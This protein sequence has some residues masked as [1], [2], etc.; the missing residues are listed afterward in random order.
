MLPFEF[1]LFQFTVRCRE[2]KRAQFYTV[3]PGKSAPFWPQQTG[4]RKLMVASIADSF[5]ETQ[6]FE[7]TIPN[8]T[9]LRLDHEVKGTSSSKQICFF[10][11]F[12]ILV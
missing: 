6:P 11:V 8:I 5:F 7:F 1:T 9:F 10:M 4:A 12:Q 2:F 3:A